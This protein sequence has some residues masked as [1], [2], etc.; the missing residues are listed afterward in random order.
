MV[1]YEKNPNDKQ[2]DTHEDEVLTHAEQTP[3]FG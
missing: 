2:A 3:L 1:D